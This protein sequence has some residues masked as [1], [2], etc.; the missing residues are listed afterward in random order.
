VALCT[1]AATTPPAG[2]RELPLTPRASRVFG[3]AW[4]KDHPLPPAVRAFREHALKTHDV[5]A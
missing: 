1:P 5:Q 4:L 2:L 3:L